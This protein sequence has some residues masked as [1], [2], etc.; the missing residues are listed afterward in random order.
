MSFTNDSQKSAKT[1]NKRIIIESI[2]WFEFTLI[3]MK[4]FYLIQ[5]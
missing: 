3:F 1:L 4:Y 5:N 2:V